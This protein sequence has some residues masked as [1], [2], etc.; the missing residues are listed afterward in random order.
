MSSNIRITRI[1]QHCGKEFEARTTV[2]KCCS[3][4]CAK[5][6]YKARKKAEKI[7]AAEGE[8]QQIREKP[9]E[10]LKVKEFLSITEACQLL[11]LSRWTLWRAIKAKNIKAVKIGQRTIIERAEI[12]RLFI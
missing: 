1:C 3:D 7:E 4:Y 2:T 5:R 6:A 9:L 8:T 11:G 12:N 10:E